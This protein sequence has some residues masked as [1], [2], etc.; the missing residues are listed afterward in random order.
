MRQHHIAIEAADKQDLP[1]QVVDKLRREL[2]VLNGLVH[3][4]DITIRD[5]KSR[6]TRMN[7]WVRGR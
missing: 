6:I 2:N 5:L 1:S 3:N 7:N 4:E